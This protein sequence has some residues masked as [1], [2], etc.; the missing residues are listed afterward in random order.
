[1]NELPLYQVDAFAAGLFSGN[2]AAVCPLPGDWL[3]DATMQAVAAE[4]NLA[5]TAFLRAGDGG[6][7]IRWFTPKLEVDLCGHAT[8]ASAYVVHKHLDPGCSRVRFQSASGPLT[9]ACGG[10]CF[11]LDFPA[12]PGRPLADDSVLQTVTEALG[13]APEAVFMAPQMLAVLASAA[14]VRGVRPKLDRLLALPARGLIVTGPG[15]GD[16]DFVSR[17]FAP[18][19]G[20]P[21]D[22][23]TGSAHCTLTPY[24]SA[25][26]GKHRLKAYQASA[27]GGELALEDRGARIAIGGRAVPYLKGRIYVP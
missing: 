20:I 9:V 5:E 21:E 23:V 16:W 25:R 26:L 14:E 27:R 3:P 24:W 17:Y 6:F 11:T 15:E 10:D 18:R 8:L 22:P 4:N 13:V 2:P 1:M 19:G 7:D 12:R